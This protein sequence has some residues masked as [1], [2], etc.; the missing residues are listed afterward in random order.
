MTICPKIQSSNTLVFPNYLEHFLFRELGA[1]NHQEPEKVR[2]NVNADSDMVKNYLGTYF[3]RSYTEAYFIYSDLFSSVLGKCSLGRKSELSILSMGCGTG[4]D[5]AGLITAAHQCNP[6]IRKFRITGID[7]NAIALEHMDKVLSKVAEEEDLE[8]V[9][10]P[11]H[12]NL[13]SDENILQLHT[14]LANR[15]FSII[16]SFKMGNEIGKIYNV[17]PY[18]LIAELVKSSL[19]DGG[20]FTLLDVTMPMED[21]TRNYCPMILNAEMNEFLKANQ[22]FQTILPIPCAL[23]NLSCRAQKCFMKRVFNCYLSYLRKYESSGVCFRIIGHRSFM[24]QFTYNIDDQTSFII[25]PQ[26]DCC[27]H[28]GNFEENSVSAFELNIG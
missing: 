21:G 26:G 10:E 7:A 24:S 22:E 5:V 12:L 16:Q 20:F 13:N 8:I 2:I 15:K 6:S 19:D 1:T 14:M 27:P 17:K 25:K 4:G 18:R 11:V 28:F 3:P 9:F 23:A